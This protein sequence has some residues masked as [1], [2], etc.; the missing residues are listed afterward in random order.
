[1]ASP[2]SSLRPQPPD[3]TFSWGQFGENLTTEG[4]TEDTLQIGDRLK[5]ASATLM[6]TQP[7]MPCYK[8][9]LRFGRDDMIKRFLISGR[10][11]FYFS[12][13]E[14]GIVAAGSGIEIL[15]RDP[16]QVSV[17]DISQLYLHPRRDPELV[18]RVGRLAALPENWKVELVQG[19]N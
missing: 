19:G 3:V 15:S 11:G 18:A 13:L 12:V 1:M 17:A 8:L 4:L 14:P 16:N 6:V 7:R 2:I 10:S 9:A 5:V